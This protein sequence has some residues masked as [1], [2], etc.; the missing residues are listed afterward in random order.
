MNEFSVI[1][2]WEEEN[3]RLSI[4]DMEFSP[5]L[6]PYESPLLGL[7]GMQMYGY[8]SESQKKNHS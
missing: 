8:F 2:R 4:K 5:S 3:D 7:N 1:E 6:G